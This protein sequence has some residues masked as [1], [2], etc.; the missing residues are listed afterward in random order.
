LGK[1]LLVGYLARH[2]HLPG[3]FHAEVA[4]GAVATGQGRRVVSGG[5]ERAEAVRSSCGSLG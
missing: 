2:I 3:D 4:A 1:H 5:D